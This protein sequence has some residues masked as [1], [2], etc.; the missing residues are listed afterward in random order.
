M[1]WVITYDHLDER[2]HLFGRFKLHEGREK[3]IHRFRL[4]DDDGVLYFSGLS[5]DK[6]SE[7]AFAPLDYCMDSYGC[8]RIDYLQDNDNWETL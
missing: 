6:D 3:L 8:T 1:S 4:Y 5:S 7:K 2:A